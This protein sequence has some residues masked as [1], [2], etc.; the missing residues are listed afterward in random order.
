MVKA[1]KFEL[2]QQVEIKVSGES[3]EVIGRAEYADSEN[4]YFLRYKDAQGM[5]REA[6][7]PEGALR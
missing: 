6:W 1:F 2:G 4:S 5:A 7:W 3:G